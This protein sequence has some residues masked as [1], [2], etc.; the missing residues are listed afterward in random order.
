[1]N[2]ILLRPSLPKVRQQEIVD[3]YRKFMSWRWPCWKIIRVVSAALFPILML[4]GFLVGLPAR[5]A[6][7]A[8]VFGGSFITAIVYIKTT[9]ALRNLLAE[10]EATRDDVLVH[11]PDELVRF[12]RRET[13]KINLIFTVQE[14]LVRTT[15]L[16]AATKTV[17]D[18]LELME[19][20]IH[21]GRTSNKMFK[22]LIDEGYRAIAHARTLS[23][24]TGR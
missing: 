1:M 21:G 14:S 10:I 15:Q 2:E 11:P 22:E 12:Y 17:Y 8:L 7:A 13:D 20:A 24:R 9:V 4:S 23:Q 5:S 6:E 16:F 19:H 18:C 3:S